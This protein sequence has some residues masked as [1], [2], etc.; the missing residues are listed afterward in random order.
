M[1]FL[2]RVV[3]GDCLAT[4]ARKYGFAD[5]RTIYNHP[6]NTDFRSRRTNPNII[7][8]GD[9][10]YV[11]DLD[12]GEQDAATDQRHTYVISSPLTTI[13]IRVQ[14]E[15][16]VPFAGMEYRLQIDGETRTG[17]IGG[18]G[19]IESQIP[20]TAQNGE[21]TVFFRNDDYDDCTWSLTLGC[22]DPVEE[23][24]GVQARLNNLGCICGAVDGIAGPRTASAIRTFQGRMSL[25]VTGAIDNALRE[26]LRMMHDQ[27]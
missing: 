21:L 22:L 8:P 26:K 24:S 10:I 11:P 17:K 5:W 1:A 27:A 15:K 19:L 9:Q 23:V 4:I 20:A 7:F 14:D 12:S 25:P 2:Y 3:Q 13:R 16:G 18:D 6:Q